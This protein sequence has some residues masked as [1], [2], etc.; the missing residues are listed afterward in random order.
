M[1]ETMWTRLII[2]QVQCS[3]PKPMTKFTRKV[4]LIQ[5]FQISRILLFR[6][7][8]VVCYELK[9]PSSLSQYYK[10]SQMSPG[11]PCD[12]IPSL[13]KRILKNF[14]I[15]S[16]KI[17]YSKKKP[18]ILKKIDDRVLNYECLYF[19]A[20]SFEHPIKIVIMQSWL[21]KGFLI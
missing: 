16:P 8:P 1:N 21:C 12:D 10:F 13:K 2:N 5:P 9:E 11:H 19:L 3:W 4:N 17:T 6:K 15:Y 18:A 7:I 14:I 20:M